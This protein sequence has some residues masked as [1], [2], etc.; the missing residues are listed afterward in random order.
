MGF[1]TTSFGLT[2]PLV[3]LAKSIECRTSDVTEDIE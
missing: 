1:G 3:W 2:L